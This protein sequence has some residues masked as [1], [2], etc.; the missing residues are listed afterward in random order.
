[1]VEVIFLTIEICLK[2]ACS[3]LITFGHSTT[4]KLSHRGQVM[5]LQEEIINH[6]IVTKM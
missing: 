4:L 5:F 2:E 3:I 6:V 1:M